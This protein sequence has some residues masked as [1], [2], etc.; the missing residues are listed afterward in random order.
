MRTHA[1]WNVEA[2]I[3]AAASGPSMRSMRSLSSSAALFVN[4]M[5][6]IR[7]GSTGRRRPLR[8]PALFRRQVRALEQRK[9]RLRRRFQHLVGVGPA[10]VLDEIRDPVDEHRSFT[11]AGTGQQQQWAL[12]GQDRFSLHIVQVREVRLDEASARLHIAL[13]KSQSCIHSV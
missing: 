11:A 13:F 3:S 12:R 10:A 6:M 5:A 4:V 2:Q 1:E 9:V 8:V 7:H